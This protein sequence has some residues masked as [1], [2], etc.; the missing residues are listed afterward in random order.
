MMAKI[1]K[2]SKAELNRSS[3]Q[4]DKR[5]YDETP[6][7]IPLR[8]KTGNPLSTALCWVFLL[9]FAEVSLVGCVPPPPRQVAVV[10]EPAPPPPSTKVYFYP[11]QG[12]SQ[13]QQDR[14]SYECYIW[15]KEQTGYDPS[16]SYL[17]PHQKIEVVPNPPPG[18]L[19]ALGAITG[20]MLGAAVSSRG[21]VAEGMVL[22]G[23]AGAVVGSASDSVN[24]QHSVQTQRQYD[25]QARQ[26]RNTVELQAADYR[27]AMAACLEGRG[28]NVR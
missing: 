18:T 24:Q 11:N 10:N 27:R 6:R 1:L 2:E 28:Y 22:G 17:A 7:L 20:A 4:N 13:E 19:T 16:A 26:V 3:V 9:V 23:L 14:D 21:N 25:R 15:S 8:G 5:V 12:Q